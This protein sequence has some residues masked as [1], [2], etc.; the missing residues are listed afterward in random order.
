LPPGRSLRPYEEQLLTDLADQTSLAFRNARLTAELALRVAEVDDSAAALSRSRHRI[1][2]AR[3]SERARL[4]SAI[5]RE[6]LPSLEPLPD[7]ISRLR[8]RAVTRADA[9]CTAQDVQPLIEATASALEQLREIT[10][11]VFPAQLVRAGLTPALT[12]YLG[13]LDGAAS[14]TVDA[15]AAGRRFGPAVEAAAYFSVV[16]SLRDL[17]APVSVTLAAPDGHVVVRTK[18]GE[19]RGLAP[20]VADQVRDRV[21]AAG[22]SV[23]TER[24]VTAT[25]REVVLE[26]RLPDQPR[27]G[28]GGSPPGRR[29]PAG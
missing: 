25:A 10:R 2:D 4:E 6:V 20:Q 1:I 8:D 16:E 19:G 11:G 13:R 27:R 3:D 9:D 24:L 18:G 22:G 26:V 5:R 7:A 21:E 17:I 12:S 14:L 23:T 28:S 15:S 29:C